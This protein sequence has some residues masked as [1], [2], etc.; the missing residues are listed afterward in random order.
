MPSWKAGGYTIVQYLNDHPPLHV[1][2]FKDQRL[3]ARFDLENLR[4]MT[5]TNKRHRGRVKKAL[6]QVGLI[7]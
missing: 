1:H 4:F 2:V 5:G 3:V 7:D 6:K